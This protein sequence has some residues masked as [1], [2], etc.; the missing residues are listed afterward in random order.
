MTPHGVHH[1]LAMDLI[2]TRQAGLDVAFAKHPNRFKSKRPV[3]TKLPTAAWINPPPEKKT[4]TKISTE[5]HT[6]PSNYLLNGDAKSLTRS[7]RHDKL[8]G[9][10]IL[11]SQA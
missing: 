2:A 10:K 5:Q 1:G 7:E 4:E 11:T 3:P 9:S 6:L 8:I